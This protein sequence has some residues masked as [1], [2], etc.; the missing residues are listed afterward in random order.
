VYAVLNNVPFNAKNDL[1]DSLEMLDTLH[2]YLRRTTKYIVGRQAFR[3]SARSGRA[4]TELEKSLQD[5]KA[6]EE[7]TS[8]YEEVFNG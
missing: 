5:P 1:R 8:L 2:D 3:A 4:V 6:S 7:I